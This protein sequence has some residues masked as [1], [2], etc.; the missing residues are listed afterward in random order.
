M[1]DPAGHL[2]VDGISF[3]IRAGEVL[4]VAGVQG[5]GQT[6]LTEAIMGLQERVEGS[7][8]LDGRRLDG[9]SVRRVLESGVG[10]VPEDRTEDVTKS[11][12]RASG[13]RSQ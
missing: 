5:N 2:Q 7:V 11:L 8:T 9:L 4:A 10:F 6:E 12:C 1:I 13:L 3:T